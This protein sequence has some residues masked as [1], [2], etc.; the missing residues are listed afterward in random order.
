MSTYI[1]LF[2][3]IPV[4]FNS[5]FSALHALLP[6]RLICWGMYPQIYPKINLPVY[7]HASLLSNTKTNLSPQL[8]AYLPTDVPVHDLFMFI[9]PFWLTVTVFPSIFLLFYMST[10]VPVHQYAC[11]AY[12][13]LFGITCT[14]TFQLICWGMCTQI[15][16]KINLPVYL[17]PSLLS[18]HKDLPVTTATCVHAHWCTCSWPYLVI[19]II[20]FRHTVCTYCPLT[21]CSKYS[22]IYPFIN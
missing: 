21:C 18:N 7:L 11:S 8:L 14:I 13:F 2:I 10:A 15:Y 5:S 20:S 19:L 4:Q 22:Q 6:F 12:L 3:S 1:Y 17:H 16:L 9:L